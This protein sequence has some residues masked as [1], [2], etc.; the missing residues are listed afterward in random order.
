[1]GMTINQSLVGKQLF[2]LPENIETEEV[3]VEHDRHSTFN[4]LKISTAGLNKTMRPKLAL[5]TLLS[6]TNSL[7]GCLSPKS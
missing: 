1:M 4:S 5:S 2:K 3:F 7:K 6:P